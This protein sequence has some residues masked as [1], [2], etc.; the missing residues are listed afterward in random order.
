MSIVRMMQTF[1][2]KIVDNDFT[3]NEF[4]NSV[5]LNRLIIEAERSREDNGRPVE[6]SA[7]TGI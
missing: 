3:K 5:K 1:A 6:F 7:V 2:S 4:E